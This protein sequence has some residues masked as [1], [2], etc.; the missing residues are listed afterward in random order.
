M[1]PESGRAPAHGGMA[2]Q[3]GTLSPSAL[4]ALF[5]SKSQMT[6]HKH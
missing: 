1:T 5:T 2:R 3:P 6:E 4:D